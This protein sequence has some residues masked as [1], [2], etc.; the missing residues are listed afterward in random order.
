MRQGE[1][2]WTSRAPPRSP[3]GSAGARTVFLPHPRPD[4]CPVQ[5]PISEVPLA[6]VPEPHAACSAL[7]PSLYH[8]NPLEP[9]QVPRQ[10]D[11]S[12]QLRG[13]NNIARPCSNQ[14]DFSPSPPTSPP[15]SVPPEDKTLVRGWDRTAARGGQQPAEPQGWPEAQ[16][17]MGRACK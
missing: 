8:I 15:L 7:T 12:L 9:G 6:R 17:T 3:P 10:R 11:T 16:P 14:S 1:P 5:G 4:L 13:K 2:G